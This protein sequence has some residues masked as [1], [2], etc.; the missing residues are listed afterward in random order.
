[1]NIMSVDSNLVVGV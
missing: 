1:M